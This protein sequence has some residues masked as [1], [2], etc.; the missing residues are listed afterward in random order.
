MKKIPHPVTM[1]DS[2]LCSKIDIIDTNL[3]GHSLDVRFG[4]EYIAM[5]S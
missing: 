4:Y 5:S 2:F 3:K 1:L